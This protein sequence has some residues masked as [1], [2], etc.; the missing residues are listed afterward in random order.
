MRVLSCDA[1]NRLS[2]D[3]PTLA[4]NLSPSELLYFLTLPTALGELSAEMQRALQAELELVRMAP[5]DPLFR[6]G[7]PGDSLYVL[8]QGKLAIRMKNGAGDEVI[9]DEALPHQVIG[10]MVLLTGQT[11]AATITALEAAALVKLSQAG[12]ARLEHSHPQI[13]TRL[14]QSVL[15][16]LRQQQL[17]QI[18][19]NLF[20]NLEKSALAELQ[21]KLEWR[22]LAAGEVLIRQGDAS[23][24]AYIV[25]KG[26]LKVTIRPP[27]S[28]AN[29]REQ[30][31]REM[32]AGEVV[33]EMGLLTNASRSATVTAIRATTVVRLSLIVCETLIA[34]HPQVMLRVA[35]M[36]AGRQV[37][38]ADRRSQTPA[39]LTFTLVASD[40][41][42]PIAQVAAR[43]IEVLIKWG[44]TLYLDSTRFDTAFGK[45]GAAQTRP[46]DPL[47]LPVS[48]WLS[49]QENRYRFIIFQAD[50]TWSP[51][52]ERCTQQADRILLVK[53]AQADPSL[54]RLE[55]VLTAHQ[56]LIPQELL[57]L[58]P[59]AS[60]RP[61]ASGRWLQPRQ[62]ATH[63]HLRLGNRDDW[64][65]LARRITGRAVALVLSGGGARGNA[66]I[67]VIRALLEANI[68]IDLIGGASFG[69]V[70]GSL[71]AY[72]LEYEQVMRVAR[73]YS[74]KHKLLDYT[75]PLTSLV[76]GG[77]GV[78][79]FQEVF[80][81]TAIE[82]LWLPFFAVS[83]NLSRATTTV[84][85]QGPLWL[86]LRATTAIPGVFAPVLY[87]GDILVDGGV[88][89]NFPVDIM[90]QLH[91]PGTVIGVNLSPPGEALQG[92]EFGPSVSGWQLLWNRLNPF[93]R[94]SPKRHNAPSL[95]SILLRAQEFHG[96]QSVR[97]TQGL[98]D[99]LIE[100]AVAH[101]RIDAFEAYQAVH[102]IGYQA[103]TQ[104]LAGWN[105]SE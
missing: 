104:A 27:V 101:I 13:A 2:M 29:E 3:T 19:T 100:P 15:P 58:Q 48:G 102:D 45:A 64:Q 95:M 17:L 43:L 57:L 72:D 10:E 79:Q 73:T 99:L 12:F 59:E 22:Y 53:R 49:E 65:R 88:V 35:R 28:Q 82:D 75:L 21:Q 47:H 40:P 24:A 16:R 37:G 11:R 54:D 68:P 52:T 63:H 39:A 34:Q 25:V 87:E 84:H 80:G 86:V 5:N 97:A 50:P 105:R 33:G 51:W 62:V 90:R 6:Q 8:V 41:A 36:M 91:Q 42:T 26:R 55:N 18:L 94:A 20:G 14:A 1:I 69:A 32:G 38:A 93:A 44:D 7:D 67:G 74:S 56:S 77:K 4:N 92:Y 46:D 98:V 71:Y 60:V 66:H 103:A 9:V 31:V 85:Q 78:R 76:A 89:N 81:E 30:F 23:D 96:I 61:S 70:I 83:C